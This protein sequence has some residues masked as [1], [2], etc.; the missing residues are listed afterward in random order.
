M[1]ANTIVLMAGVGHWQRTAH[2]IQQDDSA[3]KP[4]GAL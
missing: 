4:P 3:L 2:I 1:W